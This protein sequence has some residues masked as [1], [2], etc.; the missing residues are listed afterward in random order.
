MKSDDRVSITPKYLIGKVT[1]LTG[2]S[3]D[4]VRVWERR[5]GAVTPVRSDGGTRLYS[6]ADV[7]RLRRL[8]QAVDNGHSIGRAATLSEAELDQLIGETSVIVELPDPYSSVRDRFI[9]AVKAMDSALA[10]QELARAAALFTVD[11]LIKGI[12]APLLQNVTAQSSVPELGV[13]Q[14]QLA[15]WLIRNTLGTMFRLYP[16]APDARTIVFAT[17]VGD[18]YESGIWLGSLLAATKGW[19]VCALGCEVPAAE[20]ANAMRITKAR[21]L[22]LSLSV[23]LLGIEHDLTS[24]A[25]LSPASSRVLL[26]GTEAH[27]Q[28]R[29]AQSVNWIVARDIGELEA[30]LEGA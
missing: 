24:I 4:V 21:F 14:K 10:D 18:R 25:R 22:T 19:R 28:A 27:R 1:Q 11:E 15:L 2:L 23:D 5:Y 3:I 20:I 29:F 16:S 6:D 30:C 13:A 12:A 17:P 26:L 7:L 9:A 8:R